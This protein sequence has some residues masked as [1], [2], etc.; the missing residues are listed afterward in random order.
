[1]G[2]ASRRKNSKISALILDRARNTLQE[3]TGKSPE[4]FRRRVNLAQQEK[5]SHA[6]STLLKLEA[7]KVPPQEELQTILR[8]IV[9]AWNTSVLDADKQSDALAD[10]IAKLGK[11]NAEVQHDLRAYLEELIAK[12]QALFPHDRR[13]VV[14]W[15]VTAEHNTLRITATALARPQPDTEGG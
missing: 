4:N 6:L 13:S 12:K 9:L 15:D 11:G 3:V 2:K 5:I 10:V 7:P 1:M 14:S 8:F